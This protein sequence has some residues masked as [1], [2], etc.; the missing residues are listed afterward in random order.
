MS[1]VDLGLSA[2]FDQSMQVGTQPLDLSAGADDGFVVKLLP[3]G[4]RAWSVTAA[5]LGHVRGGRLVRVGGGLLWTALVS[6]GARIGSVQLSESA[7]AV[8]KVDDSGAVLW[9][10]A[11]PDGRGVAPLGIAAA[12]DGSFIFYGEGSLGRYDPA[13]T[14][15]WQILDV[16]VRGALVALP[17]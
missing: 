2:T 1:A 3:D 10:H 16:D 13:G 12:A 17:R 5:G 9:A 6:A 7:Q 14:A 11:I 8:A 15:L 4:T